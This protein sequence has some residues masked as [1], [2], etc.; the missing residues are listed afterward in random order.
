ML[1]LPHNVVLA[2]DPINLVFENGRSIPLSAVTV[3]GE[4]LKVSAPAEG[5]NPGQSFPLAA[6]DHVFGDKPSEIYAGIALLLMDKPDDAI[7]LLEPLI[8]AQSATAKIPG[9]FWMEAAQAVLVAYAIQGNTAK[10]TAIGKEISDATPAQGIDPFVTLGKALLLPSSA[11]AKDREVALTDLLTDN[12]PADVSAY[13]AFYRAKL[14][15]STKREEEALDSYL[16]VS[17]V[18]PSGGLILNAAAELRASEILSAKGKDRREE[19]IALL[20]SSILHSAGT[21]VSAEA[22]KRLESIK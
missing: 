8:A 18:Y 5:F 2:A 17:S 1:S 10:C 16:T 7:K 9:N 12:L 6:I 19:A 15:A 21:L 3:Q 20:N 11:S 13:A 4:T 22:N 14:Y